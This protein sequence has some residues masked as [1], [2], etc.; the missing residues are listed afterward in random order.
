MK[1]KELRELLASEPLENQDLEIEVWLPGSSIRLEN[2][3]NGTLIKKGN[4]LMI[5]GNLNPGSALYQN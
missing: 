1:L 4:K 3:G 5:E 2:S